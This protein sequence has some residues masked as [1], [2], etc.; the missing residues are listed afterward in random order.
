M[1]DLNSNLYQF[2]GQCEFSRDADLV[3]L[4]DNDCS[5][6]QTHSLILRKASPVFA[7]LLNHNHGGGGGVLSMEG[8]DYITWLIILNHLYP[9]ILLN[10]DSILI[11]DMVIEGVLREAYHYELK[12]IV[13]QVDRE[14]TKKLKEL[15]LKIETRLSEIPNAFTWVRSYKKLMIVAAKFQ[16]PNAL[17]AGNKCLA[18]FLT[19][20]LN[21]NAMLET[22]TPNVQGRIEYKDS[23]LTLGAEYIDFT[24]LIRVGYA[25]VLF[26]FHS[27]LL[28]LGAA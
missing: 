9:G 10:E 17:V 18:T 22:Q 16:L 2:N 27:I 19:G 20:T 13:S 4:F 3:L 21:Y 26:R 23:V 12:S 25:D 15:K 24:D 7:Q 8:H 14:L 11:H 1:L 28:T 6:L 5:A